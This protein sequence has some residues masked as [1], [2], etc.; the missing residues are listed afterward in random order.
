MDKATRARC[1]ARARVFK[2]LAH[3]TRL[4][5][6]ERLEKGPEC[7]CRL[8]ELAGA[9]ISTVSKHLSVLKNAGVLR[10][11]KRGN[12]VFYTLRMPC[13]TGFF[14]CLDKAFASAQR[15]ANLHTEEATS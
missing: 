1:D 13:V 4:A 12:Q 8:T 6:V 15:G 5:M 7:V 9:D 14:Q 11:E 10:D 2:A 3:P